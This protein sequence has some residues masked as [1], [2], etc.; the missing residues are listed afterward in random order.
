MN[1]QVV[2]MF[3][4]AA[5]IGLLPMAVASNTNAGARA[6]RVLLISVDG[7]HSL[8]LVLFIKKNPGSTFAQLAGRGV[9][10]TNARTP[11]SDSAPGLLSLVTGG[12]PAATGVL[13]S[14]TY[15]RALSPPASD[16]STRR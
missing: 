14:D 1:T 2:R 16:C 10:Y 5:A 12:S 3:T 4:M 15:D 7:L 13:Y 6:K 9:I 11:V 8:D